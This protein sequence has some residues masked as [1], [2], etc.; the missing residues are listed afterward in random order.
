M[1]LVKN[2]FRVFTGKKEQAS[3]SLAKTEAYWDGLLANLE[4]DVN[5]IQDKYNTAKATLSQREEK[6]ARLVKLAEEMKL[7]AIESKEIYKETNDD[8]D[9]RNSMNAFNKMTEYNEK[10]EILVAEIKEIEKCVKQL[11]I[12]NDNAVNTLNAK[13]AEIVKAKSRLEFSD[14]MKGL[15]DGIKDISTFEIEGSEEVD[16]DYH[17]SVAKLDEMTANTVKVTSNKGN[18]DDFFNN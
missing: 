16:I 6:R 4:N 1:G 9:K 7:T 18:F 2:L 11:K 15:T 10:I 14:T 17:K 12:L 3:K 8:R 5:K 13:K